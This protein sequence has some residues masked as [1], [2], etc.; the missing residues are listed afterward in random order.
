MED[1]I[2]GPDPAKMG[3]APDTI[4][5]A[6][7]H[8]EG[9]P[10]YW[11]W[12]LTLGLGMTLI[13]LEEAIRRQMHINK[14]EAHLY[15]LRD[16]SGHLM[17]VVWTVCFDVVARGTCEPYKL[18]AFVTSSMKGTTDLLGYTD[19]LHLGMIPD[20]FPLINTHCCMAILDTS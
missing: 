7:N 9:E 13:T 1:V 3:E 6:K 8:S 17:N 14:G 18:R 2:T 4:L 12:P 10:T 16:A 11:S 5:L 15:C 19:L 20:Y